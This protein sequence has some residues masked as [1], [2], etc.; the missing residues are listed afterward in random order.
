MRQLARFGCTLLLFALGACANNRLPWPATISGISGFTDDQKAQLLD[1]IDDMNQQS[2]TT[3]ITQENIP[4]HF[5]IYYQLVAPPS[6]SPNRA[7]F[8]IVDNAQATIQ[9][10]NT[11]YDYS[12]GDPEQLL[13]TVVWH[14][15]GHAGGLQHNQTEG[16]IMY[17]YSTVFTS[18]TEDN[19][20]TF[21]NSLEDAINLGG[22]P[23]SPNNYHG[24]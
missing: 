11:V 22:T 14:E 20:D 3:L 24:G 7:G 18:Y 2:G 23:T 16:T 9:I 4:G 5:T 6:D 15:N 1:V 8:A 13:K 19:V 21:I 10:S 17:P 12:Q